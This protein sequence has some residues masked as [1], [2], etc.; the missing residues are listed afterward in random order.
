MAD[1]AFKQAA[2]RYKNAEKAYVATR[3][4]GR[5]DGVVQDEWTDS[6][7]TLMH[8]RRVKRAAKKMGLTGRQFLALPHGQAM[9]ALQREYPQTAKER[10]KDE[11]HYQRLY[12]RA[13]RIAAPPRRSR[14]AAATAG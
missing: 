5:Y 10:Q 6:I 13:Q 7:E 2:R 14:S 8:F 9:K 3:R 12:N 4:A 11:A 1:D